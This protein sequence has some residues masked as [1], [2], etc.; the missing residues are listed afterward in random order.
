[1][2]MRK[3]NDNGTA[4]GHPDSKIGDD[5]AMKS[6]AGAQA[7]RPY[8]ATQDRLSHEMLDDLDLVDAQRTKREGLQVDYTKAPWLTPAKV[9]I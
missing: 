2:G 4:P 6:L 7:S 3:V 8:L 1:M 5:A 9:R